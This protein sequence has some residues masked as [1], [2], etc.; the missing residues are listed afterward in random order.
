MIQSDIS[1]KWGRPLQAPV[2][3][4]EHDWKQISYRQHLNENVWCL[5]KLCGLCTDQH[6]RQSLSKTISEISSIHRIIRSILMLFDDTIK[7]SLDRWF[8]LLQIKTEGIIFM[9]SSLNELDEFYKNITDRN[10]SKCEAKPNC[11]NA[12]ADGIGKN[13]RSVSLRISLRWSR[14]RSGP[15]DCWNGISS[16]STVDS[17]DSQSRVRRQ[18][19]SG[20][21]PMCTSNRRRCHPVYMRESLI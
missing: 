5:K 20:R 17:W 12:F 10:C 11:R 15:L 7:N 1:E 19:R 21:A 14:I 2:C 18:L 4:A 8:L 6:T 3:P 16:F 13:T 9:R